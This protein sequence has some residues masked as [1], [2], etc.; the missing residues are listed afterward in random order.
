MEIDYYMNFKIVYSILA[1][2]GRQEEEWGDDSMKN[3]AVFS[4]AEK[5]TFRM[6]TGIFRMNGNIFFLRMRKLRFHDILTAD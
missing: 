2:T 4:N 3:F 5:G 1:H 6:N